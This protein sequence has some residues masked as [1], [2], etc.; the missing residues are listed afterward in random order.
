MESRED[1]Y[2]NALGIM[3]ALEEKV[4]SDAAAAA[5][6]DVRGRLQELWWKRIPLTRFM[7]IA[8]QKAAWEKRSMALFGAASAG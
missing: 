3:H 8:E 6:T 4:A 5:A 2:I 7:M 1:L